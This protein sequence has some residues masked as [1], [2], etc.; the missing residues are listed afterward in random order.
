MDLLK[1]VIFALALLWVLWF[2]AGGPWS[3]RVKDPFLK[4][5][6]PIGTGE[7][8]NIPKPVGTKD[9]TTGKTIEKS[10]AGNTVSFYGKGNARI[11]DATREYVEIRAPR[12]NTQP[13]RISGWTLKS[14][15]TGKSAGIG[16]GVYTPISGSMNPEQPIYLSPGGRAFI[17]TGRSPKGYSFRLNLCTGYFE[18]FQDFSPWL[19]LNCPYPRDENLPSG[20]NG[21]T[22][23]CVNYIEKIGRCEAQVQPLPLSFSNDP[24]CQEYVGENINYGA[25]VDT[26]KSDPDFYSTEWRVFLGRDQELWKAERETILL[27]DESGKVVDSVSY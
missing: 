24:L 20:P 27:L 4:P 1:F 22:D 10:P 14:S 7:T 12:T 11:A 8:Y 15:V 6:P 5:P 17:T 18:E 23:A 25:C 21:L 19:P 9:P 26:H 13:I 3:P 2:A 16:T